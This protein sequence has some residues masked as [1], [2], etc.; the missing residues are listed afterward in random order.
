M[1]KLSALAA[2]GVGAAL[3]F[4]AYKPEILACADRVDAKLLDLLKAL[5]PYI[6]RSR[7]GKRG[8]RRG[9]H[10]VQPGETFY[11]YD[12]EGMEVTWI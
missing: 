9:K 3:T 10:Y 11:R 2:L 8:L 6:Y 7:H 4:H 1:D 5:K 12:S